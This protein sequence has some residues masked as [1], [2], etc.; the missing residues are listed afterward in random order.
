MK[1]FTWAPGRQGCLRCGISTWWDRKDLG[2]QE[3][4]SGESEGLSPCQGLYSKTGRVL[5]LSFGGRE[6]RLVADRHIVWYHFVFLNDG[7]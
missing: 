4:G 6:E 5:D 1:S 2:S 3:K 7:L